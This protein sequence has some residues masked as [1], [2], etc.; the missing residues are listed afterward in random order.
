M[1]RL[2]D[3]PEVGYRLF[4]S[5]LT[6]GSNMERIR[7]WDLPTRLFH[8]ALVVCVLG[9]VVTANLGG[10]AMDWH[11][12]FGFGVLTLLMFRA[13]W[14]FM[15]G[16][17]SRFGSFAYSPMSLLRYLRGE[18]PA[19]FEAGHNPTGALSVWALLL[20]LLLQVAT[21]LVADDE[22]AYAGPLSGMVSS[23]TVSWATRYHKDIGKV[24]V[25][26]LVALHLLAIVYYRAF[27]HKDL[28]RPMLHGDK[29]LSSPVEPSRDTAGTRW[30]AL[31]ILLLC[32]L[33]VS[34][35]VAWGAGVGL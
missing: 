11:F 5:N 21:G 17:W 31:A 29:I 3:F 15:G 8:W 12:R 7:I 2:C 4:H 28:V 18:A 27:K 14:G 10:N 33:V 19:A 24:V 13:V 22:I 30:L 26:A 32:A 34:R 9:L 35:L 23:E 20:F 25:I 1:W 6:S 16:R